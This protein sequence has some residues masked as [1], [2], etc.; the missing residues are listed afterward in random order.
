MSDTSPLHNVTDASASIL[1]FCTLPLEMLDLPARL[2]DP[3]DVH[4]TDEVP[5]PSPLTVYKSGNRYTVLDGCKRLILAQ[6]ADTRELGCMLLRPSPKITHAA[7]LRIS[8]NS[9]RPLRFFEKLLFITWLSEHYD[10]R[11]FRSA[12]TGLPMEN[13]ECFEFVR[14]AS[15][16][17]E[18]ID[19][20]YDGVLELSLGPELQ[21]LEGDDRSAVL[22]FFRSYPFSRQMQREL[23]DWLPELAF[24]EH[25]PIDA[26]LTAPELSAITGDS[27]LNGPQKIGHLRDSLFNRRFPTLAGAKRQWKEVAGRVNPDPRR[28]QFKP[29]EAFEKNLLDMRITISTPE[30]AHTIFSKLADLDANEWNRL[31]YPAQLSR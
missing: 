22:S 29:A 1:D 8:L 15:C 11:D 5:L 12:C 17:K 10:E 9:S 16:D 19:A 18:I 21:R 24:R 14:L 27:R 4:D 31:I 28:V 13:R 23:L 25:C 2:F 26:I 3:R 7:L 20:V 30:E 6:R